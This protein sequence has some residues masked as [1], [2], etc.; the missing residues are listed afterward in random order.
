MT[1]DIRG[2][3]RDSNV[4]PSIADIVKDLY[5]THHIDWE[6]ARDVL[7]GNKPISHAQVET[8]SR[9]AAEKAADPQAWEEKMYGKKTVEP[10]LF[11][12]PTVDRKPTP[13][14]YKTR[15]S[16]EL[17]ECLCGCGEMKSGSPFLPGHDAKLKS[18]GRKIA[19]RTM[20][21]TRIFTDKQKEW[22]GS[23][24]IHLG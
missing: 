3:L 5:K 2:L 7:L 15:S 21:H 13:S 23:H 10:L 8:G 20:T 1:N 18:V 6:G 22:L 24:G 16:K 9:K 17:H 14:V 19:E 12:A 11:K 4:D